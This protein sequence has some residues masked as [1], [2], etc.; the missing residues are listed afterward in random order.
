[1]TK[2]PRPFRLRAVLIESP[3]PTGAMTRLPVP[4]AFAHYD[5]ARDAM[6]MGKGRLRL[7]ILDRIGWQIEYRDG[8][9]L[10]VERFDSEGKPV[11][12]HA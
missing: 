1:M 4:R 6:R 12:R 9:R 3:D 7:Q 11:G 8:T 5:K 10:V 2:N